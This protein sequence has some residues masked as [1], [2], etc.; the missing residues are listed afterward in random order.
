MIRIAPTATISPNA[1]IEDST[2]DTI[3]EIG[4]GVVIDSFVKIKPAGGTGD[5]S[6]GANT[7]VNAGVVI[8]SGNGVSIGRDCAIAANCTFAPVNHEFSDRDRK[9]VE[10]RFMPSRGGVVVEDDVWVGANVVLLDGAILRR[11]CV[12]GAGAVVRNECPAGSINVGVPA[13]TIGYRGTPPETE[14]VTL[15]AETRR[16]VAEADMVMA[17]RDGTTDMPV[18]FGGPTAISGMAGPRMESDTGSAGRAYTLPPEAEI[19]RALSEIG[20]APGPESRNDAA[21][22]LRGINPMAARRLHPH[23]DLLEDVHSAARPER[24]L[25]LGGVAGTGATA[26][27]LLSRLPGQRAVGILNSDPETYGKTLAGIPVLGPLDHAES[28]WRDGICDSVII[29]F[30]RDVAE[31]A[32]WFEMLRME[33]VPFA[34]LIDPSARI[35]SYVS[36]GTGNLIMANARLSTAVA[37]G[38]NNFLAGDCCVEHHS[39][40]GSHCALGLRTTLAD[41]VTIGDHV[42]S[43][44]AVCVDS[45][46][47][48]G[49]R[50]RIAPGSVI[51]EDVPPGS[52]V[53]TGPAP[54]V[55]PVSEF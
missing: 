4:E 42:Q 36:M 17:R 20:S 25:L 16:D 41:S 37:I 3:I 33:G 50:S 43:G 12:I 52:L 53:Q 31:R 9:I 32:H 27:D 24:I 39:R 48:I 28:L 8:Y 54:T 51:T 5:V 29:L 18:D 1:D 10:Q 21:S 47:S 7:V 55:R 38:D 6:I 19:R 22:A 23:G 13:R 44:M 49:A 2:R 40:I 15:A 35:D 26:V 14:P 34:N 11:G 46:V 30:T 45:G